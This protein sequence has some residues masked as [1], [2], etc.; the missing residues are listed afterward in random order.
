MVCLA[1]LLCAHVPCHVMS[2]TSLAVCKPWPWRCI[3]MFLKALAP[4]FETSV[5]PLSASV[6]VLFVYAR[7]ESS[8][9][10]RRYKIGNWTLYLNMM[11]CQIT[12]ENVTVILCLD[13]SLLVCVH[14]CMAVLWSVLAT[15]CECTVMGGPGGATVWRGTALNCTMSDHEIVLLHCHFVSDTGT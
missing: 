6:H 10:W 9:A 1:W 13:L 5:S 12:W 14:Q 11:L 2:V 8:T 3:C 15:L 7:Q 4:N